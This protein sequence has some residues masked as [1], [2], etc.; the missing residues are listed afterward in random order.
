MEQFLVSQ[1]TGSGIVVLLSLH[2]VIQVGKFVFAMFK[3]KEKA[4]DEKLMQLSASVQ[5]NTNATAQLSS[6]FRRMEREL[7]EISKYRTDT[8]KLFSSVKILAGK[9]WPEIR[10]AMEDDTF[11]K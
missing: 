1:F 8:Q 3:T 9:R 4:S 7:G 2:L 6:D 11:S 10:K 5:Q